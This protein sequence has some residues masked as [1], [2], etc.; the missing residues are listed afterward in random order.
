M[1]KLRAGTALRMERLAHT[2]AEASVNV[3]SRALMKQISKR[4]KAA[5][6]MSLKHLYDER[7][8]VE[9]YSGT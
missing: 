6:F 1:D 8:L 9:S 4:L 7:S 5:Q 3:E 2:D